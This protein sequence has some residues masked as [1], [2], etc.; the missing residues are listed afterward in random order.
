MKK[1]ALLRGVTP[2]GKNKIPKMSYLVEILTEV[3][4]TSVQTYIQSGNII[5]ETELANE[6]LSQLIHQTIKEKIGAEL[7]VIITNQSK[8][9]QAIAENP[10]G[11]DYDSSRVHLFFTNDEIN[12]EK[13]NELLHQDFGDE[14]L[15]QRSQCLYLYLP[16]DAQKKK[17]N[18]NYLEKQ[19]G[20]TA[21]M[22]KLSVVSRLS[23]MAV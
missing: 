9:A 1:V 15:G 21:T 17:L 13:L 20:I 22:R 4:L 18:T 16:R 12:R 10:F 2:V 5:C 3:G 23:E 19:L 8:L 6:Q 7:A 11:E 14:K